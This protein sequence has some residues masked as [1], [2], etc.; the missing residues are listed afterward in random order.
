METRLDHPEVLTDF[1]AASARRVRR[2]GVFCM[3]VWILLMAGDWAARFHIFHWQDQWML[4]AKAEEPA[5][6]DR[7]VVKQIEISAQKGGGLTQMI[8]VPWLAIPYAESHPA[9][10]EYRDEWGYANTPLPLGADYSV[11]IIGDSFMLSLGTQ[12]IAQALAARG[13]INV[14][15]HAARGAGPFLETR[16]FIAS[17]F[18]VKPKVVIWN[19]SARELGAELFLRQPVADWFD[20]AGTA[21]FG[22]LDSS[23]GI[24]WEAWAPSEL[25]KA[26]PNTSATAF[27]SRRIWAQ[28]KMLI[29]RGWPSDVLGA[30]DSAFGPMLFYRENLRVLPLL[31]AE[32]D[33]SAVVETAVNVARGFKERGME[34]VVLLVPEKEQVHA[35]ALSPEVQASLSGGPAL[36]SAIEQ[37]L[38]SNGITVVNMMPA[39]QEATAQ[40]T[41]VYWRDDTHWNDEG[42]RMTAEKLWT[43]TEPLLQ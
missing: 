21:A 42:I 40:G 8:P 1:E 34:L 29:F 24:R 11:V 35:R 2:W 17:G 25:R 6:T 31:T 10:T 13:D 22:L 27:F 14:Y 38:N 37:G 12:N 18:R 4:K 36:L 3:V 32:A 19:L 39:F 23:E 26:W 5:A 41:R 30:E 7:P 20:R 16:R 9:Y 33:A 43:V 15:N 28:L